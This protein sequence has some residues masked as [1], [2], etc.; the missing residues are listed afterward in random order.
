VSLSLIITLLV[1]HFIGDFV[2]QSDWMALNKSKR[3]DA[4]TMHVAVYL[5]VLSVALM[6]ILI[7]QIPASSST[8][9][10][11][12]VNTA[13]HFVTD[14]VTS[15]ITTRLWFLQMTRCDHPDDPG[16]QLQTLGGAKAFYVRDTG[17]RHWFFVTIGADQLLHSVTLLVTASWWLQ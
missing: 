9:T 6:L 12:L 3:W 11:L 10:F 5:F 4:L 15:R 1:A 2:L 13:A 8:G 16:Y 14:A 7:V 17:T